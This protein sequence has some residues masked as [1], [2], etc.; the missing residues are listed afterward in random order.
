MWLLPNQKVRWEEARW[1]EKINKFAWHTKM[2]SGDVF[3]T[4]IFLLNT[5]H[6]LSPLHLPSLPCLFIL[7]SFLVSRGLARFSVCHLNVG[8]WNQFV[9]G[10]TRYTVEP[11]LLHL[12]VFIIM[13]GVYQVLKVSR[14]FKNLEVW[15]RQ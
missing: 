7:K 6:K 5:V 4:C 2:S 8:E 13:R 1:T 11:N 12:S 15:T 3:F 9:C 14:Q 10:C